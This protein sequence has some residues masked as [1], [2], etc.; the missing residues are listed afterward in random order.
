MPCCILEHEFQGEAAI[1]QT[2]VVRPEPQGDADLLVEILL[3]LKRFADSLGVDGVRGGFG[4]LLS[5]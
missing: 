1:R 2:V 4:C 5:K 3:P